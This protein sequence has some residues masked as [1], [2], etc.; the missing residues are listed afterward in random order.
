ML[1]VKHEDLNS[2]PR[3]RVKVGLVALIC[4]PDNGEVEGKE[5]SL[6]LAGQPLWLNH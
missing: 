6:G 2:I 1:A 3:T 5:A 4:H